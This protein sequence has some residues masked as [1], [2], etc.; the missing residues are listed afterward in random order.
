MCTPLWPD[1]DATFPLPQTRERRGTAKKTRE[2][3]LGHVVNTTRNHEGVMANHGH[4]NQRERRTNTPTSQQADGPPAKDPDPATHITSQATAAPGTSH[5]QHQ[6]DP[7]RINVHTL[8]QKPP[9]TRGNAVRE[10]GLELHSCPC[11]HWE[12]PETCGIPP[13]PTHIR[14][15]PKCYVA[16]HR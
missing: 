5:G 12:L 9:L 2:P 1:K 4:Q 7:G 3:R 16:G 13:D 14:P 11:K 15:G 8:K 6:R 10:V